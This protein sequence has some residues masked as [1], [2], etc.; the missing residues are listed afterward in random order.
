MPSLSSLTDSPDYLGLVQFLI[1]PFLEDPDALNVDLE[2]YKQNERVWI[3]LAFD[4]ADKGKVFGRGGRNLQAIRSILETT[5]QEAGR[6]VHL[7]VYEGE[8]SRS[9]RPT[10]PS[11]GY[12][13]RPNNNRRPPRSAPRRPTM[14]S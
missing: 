5:A 8:Q 11:N 3:R 6:S 9:R 7:E 10:G 12:D 13:R 4:E 14:D 2:Y 1:K